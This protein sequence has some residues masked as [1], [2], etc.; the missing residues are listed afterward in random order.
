[1]SSGAL[2][3]IATAATTPCEGALGRGAVIDEAYTLVPENE[4]HSF[5]K[6]AINTVG[7]ACSQD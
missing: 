1:M 2:R 5:G 4:G 3:G 7:Y 6:E